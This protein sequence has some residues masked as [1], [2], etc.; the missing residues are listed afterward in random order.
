MNHLSFF[1]DNLISWT[2]IVNPSY[3]I[4]KTLILLVTMDSKIWLTWNNKKKKNMIRN[5]IS[6]KN[7]NK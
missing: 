5:E 2:E 6:E 3:Q 1:V 7:V 4:I